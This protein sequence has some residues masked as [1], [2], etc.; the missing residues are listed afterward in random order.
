MRAAINA[1]HAE[2]PLP[3][4][5]KVTLPQQAPQKVDYCLSRSEVAARIRVARKRPI[6]RH[7]VRMLLIGVYTGT[8]PGAILG[9]KWMRSTTDGWFDLESETLHRRGTK[10]RTSN[11]RQ[12][13]AGIHEKLLPRLRHW[14][15][16]DLA[17]GITSVV[18]YQGQPITKLTY[19]WNS[20]AKAAGAKTHDS[21][22][23]VRHT[24]ATWLMR[25]KVDTA[26]AAAYLGITPTRFG[27]STAITIRTSKRTPQVPLRVLRG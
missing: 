13:P 8:R 4:V 12:P 23:I 3:S 15:A 26:Q 5:P 2:H 11:K 1:Y 19:A 17:R 25:R 20:V 7:V 24:A 21:P 6:W 18:H 9:L 14:R 16:A 22:H 10:S 27:T